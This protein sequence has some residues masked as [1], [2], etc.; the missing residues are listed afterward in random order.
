MDVRYGNPIEWA[1]PCR[2]ADYVGVDILIRFELSG[3]AE[4]RE[5]VA[6]WASTLGFDD[7][8]ADDL[9]L[10]VHELAANSVRH[11]GGCG[12]FRMWSEDGSLVCE[13][14]DRGWITDLSIGCKLPD[15]DQHGG[16]GLWLVRE[17]CDE[18]ELRSS[19]EGTV[20]RVR[21]RGSPAD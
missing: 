15:P 10:A 17:L 18:V 13:V 6:S 21:M 8:K 20:I 16:R 9:V 1:P 19:K 3:L 2:T 5:L 11:G 4:L 12:T 14:G 7:D